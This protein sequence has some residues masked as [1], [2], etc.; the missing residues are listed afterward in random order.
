[1]QKMNERLISG[2]YKTLN[3][4][5]DYLPE[6]VVGGGWAPFLYYRYLFRN[7]RYKP[8][9]TRDIDF[10]VKPKLPIIGI[11]TVDRLLVEAGLKAEF[12]SRDNP[13]IIHYEGTIEG[14]DVEIEFLTDQTGSKPDAVLKVQEGLHAEAL[15]YVSLLIENTL[16]LTIDDTDLMD[17][18]VPLAVKVP[19]PAAYIFQKGLIL[20]RRREYQ[21]RAKDLYYIFD[22]LAGS[23]EI[24]HE[25]VLEFSEFRRKHAKWHHSFMANLGELFDGPESEGVLLVTEQRPTDAYVGLDEIQFQHY[26]FGIVEKFIKAIKS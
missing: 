26:A 3:I 13:P 22:I 18:P 1:M 9:F 20:K 12:K 19:T 21:K 24:Q 6:I 15:R 14:I 23:R 5:G 11:K 25:L 16:V 4:L 10:L 8:V 17:D 7:R 2:L